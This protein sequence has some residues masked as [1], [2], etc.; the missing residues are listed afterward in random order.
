MY[1]CSYMWLGWCGTHTIRIPLPGSDAN[2]NGT[3]SKWMADKTHPKG[4]PGQRPK[5]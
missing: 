2:S 5:T 3:K 1:V 4:N